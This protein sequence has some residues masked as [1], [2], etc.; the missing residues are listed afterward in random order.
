MTVPCDEVPYFLDLMES[1]RLLVEEKKGSQGALLRKYS[2]WACSLSEGGSL[3]KKGFFFTASY[4]HLQAQRIALPS[5]SSEQPA[6][7]LLQV[8][9]CPWPK[10]C[11]CH[12]YLTVGPHSLELLVCAV[13]WFPLPAIFLLEQPDWLYP[14]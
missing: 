2:F 9:T 11:S 12:G 14:Y 1:A 5:C 6:L 7:A 10:P 3:N 8:A 13:L 4:E